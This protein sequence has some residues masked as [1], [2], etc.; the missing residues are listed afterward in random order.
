MVRRAG[1]MSKSSDPTKAM[2]YVVELHEHIKD[3]YHGPYRSLDAA[4]VR[5][6]T[7]RYYGDAP[8]LRIE[9]HESKCIATYPVDQYGKTSIDRPPLQ[10]QNQVDHDPTND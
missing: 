3:T 6:T 8:M 1:D 4:K 7:L 2:Y 5:V 10:G 9:K